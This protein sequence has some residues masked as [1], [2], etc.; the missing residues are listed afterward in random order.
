MHPCFGI[1]SSKT[2]PFA[3]RTSVPLVLRTC[4][5]SFIHQVTTLQLKDSALCTSMVQLEHP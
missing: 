1:A 3:A 5:L 4:N 2:R